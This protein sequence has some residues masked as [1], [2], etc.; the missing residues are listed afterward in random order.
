M[1]A[2]IVSVAAFGYVAFELLAQNRGVLAEVR[3]ESERAKL[4]AA[5]DAGLYEA[6][7]WLNN[8]DPNLRWNIDGRPRVVNF[9]D[10]SLRITVEDERGKIPLNGIIEEEARQ[11]FVDAGAT[12]DQ[13]NILSDSF[14]DWEDVD[15]T[16]RPNGAEAAAYA[17]MGYKP[18]NAGFRSVGELH[19]LRG[20]TD[21]LFARI[22]PAVT[23]FFG[24]SGGFAE[25]TSQPLAL[26][27]LGELPPNAPDVLA[28]QRQL[29]GIDPVAVTLAK[30][31]LT[32]RTLMVRVEAKKG[33]AYM[34]RSAI[35]E[36][37]GNGDQPFWLRYLD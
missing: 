26:E 12:P 30:V 13:V 5:C 33:G 1:I 24:E 19:M 34:K 9:G 37:T 36:M 22:A 27:V 7:A 11:L 2:A 35:V 10:V 3:G 29:A 20:M 31:N 18:R 16:P 14:E 25:N 8:D 4:E 21:D 15:N 23:V 17:P 6:M 32:G 28:R